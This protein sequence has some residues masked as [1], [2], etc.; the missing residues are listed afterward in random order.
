MNPLFIS[1]YTEDPY[2][3]KCAS[4]LKDKCDLLGIDIEIEKVKTLGGYWKNTLYKPI[5]LFNK[6]LDKKRDIIW[7]DCDTNIRVY[8]DCF[9]EWNS[10]L[11][12][13]SHT[14]TLE[15]IKASPIGI[16]Y[17]NKTLSF[18]DDWKNQCNSKIQ[19]NDID[20]DHDI[21]KYEILSKFIDKISIE[22]MKDNYN[23]V[24]FTNGE[25]INNGIS[26]SINKGNEMRIVIDKNKKRDGIF[27]TLSLQNFST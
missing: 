15:G 14:G 25:V 27:N 26:R 3:E 7:I 21:F 2:Y 4:V 23:Y 20:L 5:Y 12:L 19:N 17:N 24:D 18:L 16:K 10:D 1:Y 22:L 13:A 6:I 8:A 9:K 11:L